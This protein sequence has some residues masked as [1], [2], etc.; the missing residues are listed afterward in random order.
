MQHNALKKWS[1]LCMKLI[2]ISMDFYFNAHFCIFK[3]C[4]HKGWQKIIIII[5]SMARCIIM[6]SNGL[7]DLTSN[8]SLL[9][10][11]CCATDGSY[12]L[13]LGRS[14]LSHW[15]VELGYLVNRREMYKPALMKVSLNDVME[16]S[17]VIFSVMWPENII[18]GIVMLKKHPNIK[19]W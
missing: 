14:H 2:D 13:Y 10:Q 15:L 19:K 1:S 3:I 18:P 12:R 16:M 8:T 17:W 7:G 6:L 9:G 5:K 4:S 11:H